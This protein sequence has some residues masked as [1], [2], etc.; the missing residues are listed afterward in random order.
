[1]SIHFGERPRVGWYW[2]L[3]REVIKYFQGG[4]LPCKVGQVDKCR[5][6]LEIGCV[7]LHIN[8]Y[9]IL[10]KSVSG[11]YHCSGMVYRSGNKRV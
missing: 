7:W 5:Y 10:H 3:R 1:M 9:W 2:K 11:M 4:S 6:S 8:L